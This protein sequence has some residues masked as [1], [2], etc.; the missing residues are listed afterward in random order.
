MGPF[1]KASGEVICEVNFALSASLFLTLPYPFSLSP[2]PSLPL[3]SRVC[4]P[5]GLV[6]CSLPLC[7]VKEFGISPSDI[8]FSQGSRPDH[9]PTNTF[10][11]DDFVATSPSRLSSLSLSHTE[12]DTWHAIS[13]FH[14]LGSFLHRSV[15]HLLLC[16]VPSCSSIHPHLHHLSS[17]TS[18]SFSSTLC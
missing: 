10:D 18:S 12:W 4:A 17:S 11:Y 5:G 13:P 7:R 16:C 8:P 3:S 2:L 9:S 1:L 6:L 14:D 15:H